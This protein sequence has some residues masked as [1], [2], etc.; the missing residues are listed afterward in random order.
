MASGTPE[1]KLT[2][3]MTVLKN[4]ELPKPDYHAVAQEAGARDPNSAQKKFRAIVKAAGF[5]LVNGRVVGGSG[6]VSLEV[7]DSKQS[8]P[9]KKPGGKA[10]AGTTKKAAASKTGTGKNKKR[11][12]EHSAEDAENGEEDASVKEEELDD[13][14]D[15][16]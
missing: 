11:K 13:E 10:T 7:S 9:V 8:K 3:I 14:G 6:Q 4:T 16:A 2:Y 12:I 1:E 5:D 15:E